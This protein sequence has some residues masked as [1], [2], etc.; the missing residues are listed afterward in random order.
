MARENPRFE[1]RK[2]TALDGRA[3]W[4]I[5]DKEMNGWSTMVRHLFRFRTRKSAQAHIDYS[6]RLVSP[7]T[8]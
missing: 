7:W 3:W 4:E 2:R 6:E 5:W 1:P 8:I